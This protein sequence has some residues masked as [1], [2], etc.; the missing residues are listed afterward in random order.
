MILKTNDD[1][2]AN[3]RQIFEFIFCVFKKGRSKAQS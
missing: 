1:R 3:N 2:K